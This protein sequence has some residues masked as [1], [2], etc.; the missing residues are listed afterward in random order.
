MPRVVGVQRMTQ[1]WDRDPHRQEITLALD[2]DDEELPVERRV[3]RDD[4]R[5]ASVVQTG[6]ECGF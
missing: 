6:S 3:S 1:K 5:L 2:L 4:R